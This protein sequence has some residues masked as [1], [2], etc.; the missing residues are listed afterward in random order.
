M[1]SPLFAVVAH[2]ALRVRLHKPLVHGQHV[3]GVVGAVGDNLVHD[4]LV[5]IGD[6]LYPVVVLCVRL[7]S[8]GA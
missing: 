8:V 1:T 2:C 6:R 3:H 7:E 5:P 4:N